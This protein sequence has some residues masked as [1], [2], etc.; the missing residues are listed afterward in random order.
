MRPS[1]TLLRYA[2]SFAVCFL[3]AVLALPLRGW[4]D[5]ANVA[6]LFLL[7]VLLVARYLGSGPAVLS[8]FV[9]VGL[10]DY[11]F[12]LPYLSLTVEDAQYFVTFAVMLVTALT[13]GALTADLRREADAACERE[14]RSRALYGMARE[15]AG[16]VAV[17]QV[18][19][20]TR[21]FLGE[22]IAAEAT[23]LLPDAS[24]KLHPFPAGGHG[25]HP[26]LRAG[27]AARLPRPAL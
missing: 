16:A 26:P 17:E 10:F 19:E 12:V 11:F 14:R 1:S 4:L 8:A 27:R 21:R 23:L 7:A 22:A 9:C 25:L 20:I 3:T 18:V 13:T 15:L 6:M 24:E 5:T 2:I